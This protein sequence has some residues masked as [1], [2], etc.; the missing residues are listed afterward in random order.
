MERENVIYRWERYHG[1]CFSGA[2]VVEFPRAKYWEKKPG[3]WNGRLKMAGLV[4]PNRILG[5]IT[6]VGVSAAGWV[7]VAM[8]AI[9]LMK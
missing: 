2:N 6:M 8:L 7:G 4:D 1:N 5:L 9:R 3:V